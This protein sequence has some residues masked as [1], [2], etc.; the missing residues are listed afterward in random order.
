M[1]LSDNESLRQ[2]VDLAREAYHDALRQ[3]DKI[4]RDERTIDTAWGAV[5]ITMKRYQTAMDDHIAYL[6]RR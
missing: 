1:P 4:P 6:G 3:F 5:R 2:A